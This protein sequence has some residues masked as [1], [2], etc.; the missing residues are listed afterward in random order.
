VPVGGPG[1][2][3]AE[4]TVAVKPTGCP[5]TD[6]FGAPVTAV[7]VERLVPGLTVTV[8]VPVA[9]FGSGWPLVVPLPW[10]VSVRLAVPV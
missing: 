2:P 9:V 8:T 5:A 1:P 7:L 10:M 6:G 4:V 3:N